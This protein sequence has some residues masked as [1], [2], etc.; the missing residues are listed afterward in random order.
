MWMWSKE[1]NWLRIITR[2]VRYMISAWSSRTTFKEWPRNCSSWLHKNVETVCNK[3]IPW[4]WPPRGQPKYP[5]TYRT[6]FIWVTTNF[7]LDLSISKIKKKT[8]TTQGL[9]GSGSVMLESIAQKVSSPVSTYHGQWHLNN[10]FFLEQTCVGDFTF[11]FSSV[12]T[13]F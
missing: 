8:S 13:S 2:R 10:D 6:C 1:S 12:G 3:V 5:T 11:N 9:P 4:K 7:C